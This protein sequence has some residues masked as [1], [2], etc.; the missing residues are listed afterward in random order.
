MFWKL[1]SRAITRETKVIQL[2]TTSDFEVGVVKIN[3]QFGRVYWEVTNQ[4]YQ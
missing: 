4:D 2:L 3:N 1:Q